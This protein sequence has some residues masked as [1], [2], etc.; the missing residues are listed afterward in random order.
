M[1]FESIRQYCLSFPHATKD[2]QW[3]TSLLFRVGGKIFASLSLNQY[4]Q[5]KLAFKCRPE[6]YFDLIER[7][8]IKPAPYVARYHWVALERFDALS[9]QELKSLIEDSYQMVF[10]KLPG[11]IKSQLK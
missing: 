5:E 2:I 11:K 10:S 7:D 3:K 4:A 9:E 1:N 8:G 6:I